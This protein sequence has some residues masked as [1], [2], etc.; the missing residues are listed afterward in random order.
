MAATKI[1]TQSIL[2]T[3][4]LNLSALHNVCGT[5]LML[6]KK[7]YKINPF[8]N[9]HVI[10]VQTPSYSD[11]I[12][13]L[14]KHIMPMCE[15]DFSMRYIFDGVPCLKLGFIIH[16]RLTATAVNWF[17]CSTNNKARPMPGMPG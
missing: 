3:G 12:K 4:N 10:T 7:Q 1:Q 5:D 17:A 6:Q 13:R 9:G 2:Y 16:L 8:G 14:K 11:L 15:S